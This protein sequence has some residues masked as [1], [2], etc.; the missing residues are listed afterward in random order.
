M[1]VRLEVKSVLVIFVKF[2]TLEHDFFGIF[3]CIS[4]PTLIRCM[5]CESQLEFKSN[6]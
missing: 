3:K 4:W 1:H 2:Y 6:N 5:I